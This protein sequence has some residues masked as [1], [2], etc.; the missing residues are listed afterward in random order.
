MV[1]SLVALTHARVIDSRA[2]QVLQRPDWHGSPWTSGTVHRQEEPAY[3]GLPDPQPSTRM[4]RR[5]VISSQLEIV[6][7]LV[8]R[9]PN[10][11]L[12]TCEQ[13]KVATLE[14]GWM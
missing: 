8:C 10:E 5:L 7:A 13:W 1:F 4:K 2:V 3:S 12:T 14:K 9:T 6:Q 11:V